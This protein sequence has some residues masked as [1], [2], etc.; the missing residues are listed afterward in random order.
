MAM[1]ECCHQWFTIR[2]DKFAA[3]IIQIIGVFYNLF[4]F[5]NFFY[6]PLFQLIFN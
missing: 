4:P 2:S 6:S 1:G 5:F 3:K